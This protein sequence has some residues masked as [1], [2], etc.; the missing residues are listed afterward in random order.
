MKTSFVVKEIILKREK[1]IAMSQKSLD[2]TLSNV[3]YFQT[4]L[5][6]QKEDLESFKKTLDTGLRCN[7]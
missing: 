7:F 2:N 6:E 4:L 1:L 5:K 3:E